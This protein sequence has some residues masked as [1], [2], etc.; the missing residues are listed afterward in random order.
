MSEAVADDSEVEDTDSR[1]GTGIPDQN[2]RDR[3]AL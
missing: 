3:K 1:Y 2:V